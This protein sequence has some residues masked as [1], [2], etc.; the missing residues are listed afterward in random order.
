MFNQLSKVILATP[1]PPSHNNS[2]GCCLAKTTRGKDNHAF[3]PP[4]SRKTSSRG[5]P[6]ASSAQSSD[7]YSSFEG[8]LS[9]QLGLLPTGSTLYLVLFFTCFDSSS[10]LSIS[11]LFRLASFYMVVPLIGQ[12]F[13]K[14]LANNVCMCVYAGEVKLR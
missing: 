10:P 13:H 8:P 1:K 6:F 14:K 9:P 3:P 11:F 7:W 2:D 5:A 4:I 12:Y